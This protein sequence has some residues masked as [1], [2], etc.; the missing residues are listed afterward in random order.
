MEKLPKLKGIAR[1][2]LAI[3]TK[4]RAELVRA[5]VWARVGAGSVWS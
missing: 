2:T 4:T 5:I 3:T 1:P